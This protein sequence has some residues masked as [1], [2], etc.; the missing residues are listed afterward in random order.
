MQPDTGKGGRMGLLIGAGSG[1]LALLFLVRLLP[2]AI[3]LALWLGTAGFSA[4][5]ALALLYLAA[6]TT[7]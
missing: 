1:L 4:A 7:P 2:R 6:N 5:T 3:G